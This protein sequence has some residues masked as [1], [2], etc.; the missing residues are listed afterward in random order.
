MFEMMLRQ[1]ISCIA[2]Y[3]NHVDVALK[4]FLKEVE[5]NP[6]LSKS[7][8]AYWKREYEVN[9]PEKLRE[10]SF[11]LM[12]GHLEEILYLLWRDKNPLSIQ[13]DRGHGVSKYKSYI[14]DML[15]S[16]NNSDYCHIAEAQ[17]VRNSIIHIAGRVSLSSENDKLIKLANNSKYYFIEMDRIK[18]KYEGLS[19][20]QKSISQLTR[21]LLNKSIQLTA[22]ASAD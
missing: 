13:L 10:T 22:K 5:E 2:L 8:K 7:D 16:L 19:A 15:G 20:L 17:K 1:N 3:H 21:T 14:K 6:E 18:I 4:D 12:F 11:L 9:F